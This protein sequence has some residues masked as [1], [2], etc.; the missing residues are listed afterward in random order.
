MPHG[1]AAEAQ[2][3]EEATHRVALPARAGRVYAGAIPTGG[4]ESYQ[5]A[6][7]QRPLIVCYEFF[8]SVG[9]GHAGKN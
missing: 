1:S 9:G 8:K 7:P 2:D 5:S 6:R 3:H 4:F